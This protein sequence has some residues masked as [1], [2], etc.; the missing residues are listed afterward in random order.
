M[1]TNIK[2]GFRGDGTTSKQ[3]KAAAKDAV[4]IW[5]NADLSYPTHLARQLHREDLKIVS[6][7]WLKDRRFV[8]LNLSEIILDHAYIPDIHTYKC[9]KEAIA[10]IRK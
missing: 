1:A 5:L 3:M 4:F 10:R 9:F 2:Q 7:Y 6:P 8:G